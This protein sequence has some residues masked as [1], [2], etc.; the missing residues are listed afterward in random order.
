MP[1]KRPLET[2][3]RQAAQQL[4]RRD[5]ADRIPYCLIHPA[6]AR[7]RRRRTK[8]DRSIFQHAKICVPAEHP[9]I[10]RLAEQSG[11]TPTGFRRQGK[12]QHQLFRCKLCLQRPYKV[13][14]SIPVLR[15]QILEIEHDPR[16]LPCS[17]ILR[18]TADQIR[19]CSRIAQ[20]L[21]GAFA[22]KPAVLVLHRQ[23]EHRSDA[24]P[25]CEPY[26][27]FRVY[28]GDAPRAVKAERCDR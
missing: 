1:R 22:R 26:R 7:E 27:N 2:A 24:V 9:E 17:C 13:R 19:A 23:H 3:C 12:Q 8:R 5:F 14:E 20:H 18:G 25:P 11:L 16:P 28:A 10:M 6:D 15:H 4:F 21:T